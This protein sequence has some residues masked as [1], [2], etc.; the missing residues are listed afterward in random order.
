MPIYEVTWVIDVDADTPH[1]AALQARAM[2]C[3]PDTAAVVFTVSDNETFAYVTLDLQ[4]MNDVVHTQ[5]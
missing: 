5:D 4:E 2:Q 1:E 3:D